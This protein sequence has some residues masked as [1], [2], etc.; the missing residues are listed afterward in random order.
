[1]SWW[2]SWSD[3]LWV[4]HYKAANVKIT[5]KNTAQGQKHYCFSVM[6]ALGLTVNLFPLTVMD[7]CLVGL[8]VTCHFENPGDAVWV[9]VRLPSY[10]NDGIETEFINLLFSLTYSVLFHRVQKFVHP[11]ALKCHLQAINTQ[12]LYLL[13]LISYTH[14]TSHCF[15]EIINTLVLTLV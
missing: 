12:T 5:L 4:L 13:N 9:C 7:G 14:H 8:F 1:M 3:I 11:Y 10:G 6:S 15:D 2:T